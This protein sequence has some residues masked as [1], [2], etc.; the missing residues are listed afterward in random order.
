VIYTSGSTGNPKGVLLKY[1]SLNNLLSSFVDI[2]K[3]KQNDNFLAITTISFDISI[4]ELLLPLCVG[5]TVV[6]A[7]SRCQIDPYYLAKIIEKYDIT[8]MQATPVTWK[9][10]IDSN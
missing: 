7:P 9:M 3:I 2:L 4:L 8:F 1:D 10:L 5:G 6:I